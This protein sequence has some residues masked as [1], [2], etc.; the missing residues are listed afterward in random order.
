[1][2][3][4]KIRDYLRAAT[5]AIQLRANC[6]ACNRADCETSDIYIGARDE[7]LF[8]TTAPHFLPAAI[9]PSE[10]ES[11]RAPAGVLDDIMR[12]SEDDL[13]LG[14]CIRLRSERFVF[15]FD[16]SMIRLAVSSD[17][18]LGRAQ[19]QVTRR[20][21]IETRRPESAGGA[22]GARH[23]SARAARSE[24]FGT[25]RSIG[26]KRLQRSCSWRALQVRSA[27]IIF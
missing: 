19:C 10:S 15:V 6:V 4:S 18:A 20:V 22:G 1:M 7:I 25:D 16:G 8:R 9:E 14:L 11:E 21:C 26:L 2:L 23:A 12:A 24:S 13:R 3:R 17:A 27:S 5:D